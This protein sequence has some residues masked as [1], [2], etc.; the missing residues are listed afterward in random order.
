MGLKGPA[1][2]P[3]SRGRLAGDCTLLFGEK[4]F[5]SCSGRKGISVTPC[6][7][8]LLGSVLGAGVDLRLTAGI[9]VPLSQ[10]TESAD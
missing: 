2:E 3:R 8:S 5:A 1:A 9:H 6:S 4:M 10:Q 7:G